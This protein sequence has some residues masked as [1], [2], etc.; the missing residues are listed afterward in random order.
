MYKLRLTLSKKGGKEREIKLERPFMEWFDAAGHF[1]P[2][3]FWQML[4]SNVD[5]VAEAD[6][7]NVVAASAARGIGMDAKWAS[8]L[9]ES[10]DALDGVDG[11]SGD[12]DVAEKAGDEEEGEEE[13][14]IDGLA[15]CVWIRNMSACI[16]IA[17][18]GSSKA[19]IGSWTPPKRMGCFLYPMVL[20]V[21]LL[22]LGRRAAQ[23]FET[24]SSADGGGYYLSRKRLALITDINSNRLPLL[25]DWKARSIGWAHLYHMSTVMSIA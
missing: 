6:P 3:P 20:Q 9:A 22:A 14:L 21:K 11:V 13:G 25:S 24:L 15:P 2:K 16:D 17:W 7:A 4:A 18:E 10:A 5:V 19:W 12:V 23:Y 1:V 8:L